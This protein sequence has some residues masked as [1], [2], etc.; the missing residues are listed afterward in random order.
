M[1]REEPHIREY[2]IFHLKKLKVLDGVGIEMS[3]L[4]NSKQRFAGR[5]TEELLENRYK[6][7]TKEAT[8]LDLSG[9]KLRDFDE[10][11]T[12][13]QFPKLTDLNISENTL[14]SLNCFSA[15][16]TIV[17]LN[18]SRNKIDT[19]HC[20]DYQ[21]YKGL[22]GLQN[23]QILDVSFN[24]LQDLHGLNF[25][26]LPHLKR[27][28]ATNNNIQRVEFLETLNQ[29]VELDLS[30]NKIRE[31]H[32]HSFASHPNLRCL[33]LTDNMI[34]SLA[35][36]TRLGK[37]QALHLGG[38]RVSEVFEVEK[39]ADMGSLVEI[40]LMANPMSRKAMYRV[41]IIKRMPQLIFLDDKEVS[42]EEKE[43]VELINLA[44]NKPPPL[45]HLSQAPANNSKVAVKLT[46]VNFESVLP[47]TRPV[48]PIQAP[49]IERSK[50]PNSQSNQNSFN[51]MLGVTAVPL[52]NPTRPPKTRTSDQKGSFGGGFAGQPGTGGKK[53][54]SQSPRAA[55]NMRKK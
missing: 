16:P 2:A 38:N 50:R 40:V 19:L 51:G 15:M 47:L 26:K 1:R 4:K 8:K 39:I 22:A 53:S 33:R 6:G 41:G 34:K 45:V 17:Q 27:L 35:N 14:T 37:L 5:L 13:A 44:D 42:M 29:I 20:K 12:S 52:S 48:D 21:S 30:G 31:I 3:E 25:A 46:S 32:P 55:M 54:T 23:L 18:A 10:A 24:S 7:N 36:L 49:V 9:A 43:R 11:F 28:L